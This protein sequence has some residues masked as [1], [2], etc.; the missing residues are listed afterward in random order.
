MVAF[1]TK[2][3]LC[4][5]IRSP[6]HAEYDHLLFLWEKAQLLQ[7]SVIRQQF[8]IQIVGCGGLPLFKDL[9]KKKVLSFDGIQF[10]EK[11]NE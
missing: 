11:K 4:W 1:Q 7:P 10:R 2:Q 9:K 6:M 3:H 8:W 5:L